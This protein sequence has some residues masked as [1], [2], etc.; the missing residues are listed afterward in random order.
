M[1]WCVLR[2]VVTFP[3]LLPSAP[4]AS[5]ALQSPGRRCTTAPAS[6]RL[7]GTR[8]GRR[9]GRHPTPIDPASWTRART[10][11]QIWAKGPPDKRKKRK[12]N[13][14]ITGIFPARELF[15]ITV[16]NKFQKLAA[17]E[18]Y[19]HYSFILI[20]KQKGCNCNH[21]AKH[22]NSLRKS[23]TPPLILSWLTEITLRRINSVV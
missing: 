6:C 23:A 16:L 17:G 7:P 20:P 8:T 9:R 10:K 14:F 1:E 11:A 18:N 3:R 21:F 4:R 12:R 2:V 13:L 22:G 15:L 19:S 5:R